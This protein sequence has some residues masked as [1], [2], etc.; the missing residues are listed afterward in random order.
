MKM[1]IKIFGS[2]CAN[3][4]RLLENAKT[5]VKELSVEAE[6]KYIT[7]YMEIV[8]AGFLRTPGLM[9]N[10]KTVSAGRVLSADEIKA[11]IQSAN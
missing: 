9:I 7:D 11:L 4:K 1:E 6:I 3:C 10:G 8:N 5:A 2:G